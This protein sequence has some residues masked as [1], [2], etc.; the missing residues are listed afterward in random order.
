MNLA[1][2]FKYGIIIGAISG[3]LARYSG[4]TGNYVVL[5]VS[6]VLMYY[7]MTKWFPLFKNESNTEDLDDE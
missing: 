6:I 3:M 1:S 2:G 4:Q 7:I 5:Y